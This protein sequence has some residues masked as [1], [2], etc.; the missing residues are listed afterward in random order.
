[1]KMVHVGLLTVAWGLQ[2]V[3]LSGCAVPGENISKKGLVTVERVSSPKVDILRADVYRTDETLIIRGVVRRREYS[4]QPLLVHVDATVLSGA[5]EILQEATGRDV[6]AP[7]RLAGKGFNY[8]DF[9]IRLSPPVPE[10]GT[11]KLV[12]HG[13][14]REVHVEMD[15]NGRPGAGSEVSNSLRSKSSK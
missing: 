4:G 7:R 14:S 1:M 9:E 10:G 11:V 12:C 6:W 5:G 13:G 15:P 2:L 3:A 8:G